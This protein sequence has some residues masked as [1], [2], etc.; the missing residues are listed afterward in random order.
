MTIKQKEGFRFEQD[1]QNFT[2]KKSKVKNIL[3]R[4]T[5]TI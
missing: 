3:Y 2:G 5:I 1:E 4:S